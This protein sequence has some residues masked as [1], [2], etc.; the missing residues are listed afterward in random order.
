MPLSLEIKACSKFSLQ[1]PYSC[2]LILD[3]LSLVE[4]KGE[5][6]HMGLKKLCVAQSTLS[7]KQLT[8]KT[9]VAALRFVA[10]D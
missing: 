1:Q 9:F 10:T 3:T 2:Y 4:E 7:V 6:L 5:K 8:V